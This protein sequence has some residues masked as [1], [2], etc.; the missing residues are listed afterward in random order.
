MAAI[1]EAFIQEI[2]EQ[3]KDIRR[4]IEEHVASASASA[5]SSA[6]PAPIPPILPASPPS[7]TE[8]G[9]EPEAEEA[10]SQECDES[11][12]ELAP[13][14]MAVESDADAEAGADGSYSLAALS[15]KRSLYKHHFWPSPRAKNFAKAMG[16]QCRS[17][18]HALKCLSYRAGISV[19]K[20]LATNPL[21]YEANFMGS[22]LA[23]LDWEN[24]KPLLEAALKENSKINNSRLRGS[25]GYYWY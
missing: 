7:E 5:S 15:M 18:A 4:K 22:I 16:L 14:S 12:L 23:P 19:K 1:D 9:S 6:A 10:Q 8:E 13:E 2:M 25:S 21:T 3:L 11:M 20:L 24:C 17:H